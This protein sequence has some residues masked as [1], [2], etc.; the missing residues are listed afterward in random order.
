L[1]SGFDTYSALVRW[2]VD[3]LKVDGLFSDFTDLTLDILRRGR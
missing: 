2:F 3:E 1:P